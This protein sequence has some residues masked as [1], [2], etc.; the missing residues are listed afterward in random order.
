VVL[1]VIN[2]LERVNGE[3]RTAPVAVGSAAEEIQARLPRA[4]V[5]SAFKSQSAEHLNRLEEPLAGDVLVCSEHA[6]ARAW[7]LELV[8]RIANARPVDAGALINARALEGITPLLLNLNRRHRAVT[9]IQILGLH[10]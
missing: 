3:F 5:V 4:K 1:D 2:P 7:M 10:D 6:A 8:G 9:S